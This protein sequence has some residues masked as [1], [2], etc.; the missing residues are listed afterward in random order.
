MQAVS[1]FFQVLDAI[2]SFYEWIVIASVIL[3]WLFAFN[4]LNYS[5]GA[6]RIISD[7]VHRLTEPALEQIRRVVPIM[8]TLDLSPLVLFFAI[9]LVRASILPGLHELVLRALF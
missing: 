8:G 2:L 1:G 6:V 4:V 9:M 3:C 5:N 7:V